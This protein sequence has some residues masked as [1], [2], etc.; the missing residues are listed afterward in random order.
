[1]YKKILVVLGIFT[2]AFAILLVS[3]LRTSSVSYD[4]VAKNPSN[5]DGSAILGSEAACVNYVFPYEGHVL[6]D[7]PLWS[8]KAL[9]DKIW[10]SISVSPLKRAELALLFADKRLVSAQRLWEK[11]EADIAVSTLTKGEK[12]LEIAVFQEIIA[13]REGYDT[14][15][16]LTKLSTAALKHGEIIEKLLPSAPEDVR[17]VLIRTED[18]CKN[19]Y[20]SARDAL[21]SEGLPVPNNPFDWE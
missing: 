21:N 1:M 7:S 9:R 16:F 14:T 11:G 17:P 13:R 2:L 4:F 3:I 19:A 10:Y 6:P 15:A 8:V 18:Y 5:P 20:K 12:Y